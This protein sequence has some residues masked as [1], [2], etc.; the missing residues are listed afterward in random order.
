MAKISIG[1]VWVLTT[2]L[3][4]MSPLAIRAQAPPPMNPIETILHSDERFAPLVADPDRYRLQ[5]LLGLI[6]PGED[7][8][9]RLVQHGYRLEAEY[10]YPASSIK[11]CAA[12][13]ALE[14][15]G[16]LAEATDLPIEPT[17]PM[18]YHPLFDDEV[19]EAED[20]SNLK[21]GHIT[22]EHEIR[23]LFL[24]SDNTAYNRLYE[25]VGQ[26]ALNRSMHRA[27][28]DSA[29][30]VHR[31]SEFRTVDENRR[32]PRITFQGS[33]F[34]HV[35]PP[36]T[37]RDEIV[38]ITVGG[39]DIGRAFLRGG[40][41][42]EK[43][44]DFRPKNRMAL[45]DL[46]RALAKVVRPDLDL[47][48]PSFELDEGQ[49]AL[50]LEPMRQLPRESQNPVYEAKEYPDDY[51]KFLLPGLERLVPKERLQ[52]FNKIGQAYGFSTENAY[53]KD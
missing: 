17:T 2:I 8:A 35:V 43:P 34:R 6:E 14:E 42:I 48:S 7:G 38:P 9:P 12:V 45:A 46:Q 49:R 15:V 32:M 21:G 5:V 23:K 13:A 27:G 47:G 37:S 52:I 31:L 22:I 24:V 11:L 19:L 50:L 10:F 18:I 39:L 40:E 4:W 36:R 30:I 25:L 33:E 20:P 3:A 28:L 53:V 44:L 1:T 41:T 29:R 26:D 16:R 51:V